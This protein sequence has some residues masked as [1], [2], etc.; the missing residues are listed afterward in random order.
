RA[1]ARGAALDWAA[2]FAG[3]GAGRVDLPT[4]AFQRGRYWLESGSGS[5]TAAAVPV[6]AADARF[7][8]AVEREDLAGLAATLQVADGDEL[9]ALLPALSAWRRQSREQST[10][11]GWRYR[12]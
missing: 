5:A 10:V 7:W 1:H 8:D 6:D 2:F 12:V 3:R 9:G 4:Y 11:D